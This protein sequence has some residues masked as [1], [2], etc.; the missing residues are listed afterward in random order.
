[1]SDNSKPKKTVAIWVPI[2][3]GILCLLVG[4]AA[5]GSS[6]K[7]NTASS[8]SAATVTVTTTTTDTKAGTIPAAAPA[9][10]TVTE[11]TTQTAAA[12]S[13]STAADTGYTDGTYIVGSDIKPGTYKSAGPAAGGIGLCYW[14]RD[15][16]TD[17]PL[18]KIIANDDTKGQAV[19]NISSSDYSVTF[20]GC[21]PFVKS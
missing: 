5:A 18:S 1:M 19:I 4:L 17:D 2:V 9:K 12:P 14:E 13:P 10:V 7:D 16:K 20:T 6:K 8:A 3:V 11:T 15:K 21:Q